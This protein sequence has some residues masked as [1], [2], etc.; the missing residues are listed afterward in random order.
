MTLPIPAVPLRLGALLLSLSAPLAASAQGARVAPE[1]TACVATNKQTHADLSAARDE[2][3]RRNALNAVVV[4]RLQSLGPTLAKL[5]EASARAP[6]K[7]ADCEQVTQDLTAA[8]EQFERI[9]GSPEQVTECSSTNQ[10]LQAEL[11]Q[12]L[13]ALQAAGLP[14]AQL[15]PAAARVDALRAGTR[16]NPTL[17]EC[18]QLGTALAEERVAL[19]KLKPP[20]PP[21]APPPRVVPTAAA[22]AECRATQSKTY[23]EVAQSYAR[24]VGGGP[25]PPAWVAPLQSLSERLTRLHAAL[26]APPTADWDCAGVTQALTQASDELAKLRR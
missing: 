8:K 10:A 6:R 22:V 26:A 20:P 12:T 23:N 11:Q 19:N 13:L 1:I 24:V 25:L 3:L 2:A 21:P 14:N 18:R 5:K 9:V 15:Q 7:L 4:T 16:E 17:A